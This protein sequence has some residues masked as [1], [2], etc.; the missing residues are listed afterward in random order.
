MWEAFEELVAR[1]YTV[2]RI[3]V[4]MLDRGYDLSEY[5]DVAL[6]RKML[7]L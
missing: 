2:T 3:R 6:I 5:S 1:N 4:E 7:G